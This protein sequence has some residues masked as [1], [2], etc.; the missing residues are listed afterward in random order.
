MSHDELAGSKAGLG[1]SLPSNWVQNN[2]SGE[3]HRRVQQSDSSMDQ[4][5]GAAASGMY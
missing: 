4:Q 2:E 1:P 5:S 3:R